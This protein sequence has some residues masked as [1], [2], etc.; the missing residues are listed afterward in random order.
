MLSWRNHTTHVCRPEWAGPSC[1]PAR[2]CNGDLM[3]VCSRCR[4]RENG[5]SCRAL[6]CKPVDNK[7]PSTIPAKQ[8][9]RNGA[10]QLIATEEV[11]MRDRIFHNLSRKVGT[12]FQRWGGLSVVWPRGHSPPGPSPSQSDWR[13]IELHWLRRARVKPPARFTGVSPRMWAVC[14]AE[15]RRCQRAPRRPLR[16]PTRERMAFLEG[17]KYFSLPPSGSYC[18]QERECFSIAGAACLLFLIL[19]QRALKCK[20]LQ[21][22]IQMLKAARHGI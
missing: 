7:M 2:A 9:A 19:A 3:E 5:A 10:L 16:D 20:I 15:P 11:F 22:S 17:L 13:S 14:T 1:K 12:W 21:D 4:N 6:L 18:G 8:Q